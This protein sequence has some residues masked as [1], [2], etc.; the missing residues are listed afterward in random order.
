[1]RH[2]SFIFVLLLLF[3]SS[4]RHYQVKRILS[5][6]ESL[7]ETSP[8]SALMLLEA[9]DYPEDLKSPQ[10]EEYNLYLVWAKDKCEKDISSDTLVY[11][12]AVFFEKKNELRKAALA[13][14]YSGRVAFQHEELEQTYS[15]LIKAK[16]FA[17]LLKEDNLLGLISY[18][19]GYMFQREFNW[20]Q[21][22]S[23][24]DLAQRYFLKAENKRNAHNIYPVIAYLYLLEGYPKD[25]A[26][27]YYQK[28]LDYALE[29]KDSS[30]VSIIYKGMGVA[31]FENNQHDEAREYIQKAIEMDSKGQLSHGYY[32]LLS[33][34]YMKDKEY[35][36]AMYYAEKFGELVDQM[37]N[38]YYKQ[39]Y[40]TLLCEIDEHSGNYESA[41]GRYKALSVY[42]DG[43]YAENI[44]NSLADVQE[45][46]HAERIQN[47]YNRLMVHRQFLIIVIVFVLLLA[48]FIFWFFSSMVK[49]KNQ[50]LIEAEDTLEML[51]NMLLEKDNRE[52]QFKSLLI[53]KLDIAKKVAQMEIAPAK[54]HNLFLKR[55]NAVFD[56]NLQEVLDWENLYPLINDLY[57]GFIDK[58]TKLFP[59]LNEKEIQMCCLIRAGFSNNEIAFILAYTY[60][61][62]R[63]RKVDLR[64]KMGFS[65]N[66][67]FQNFFSQD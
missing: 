42:K 60:E 46:Y 45:K 36:S 34:S 62:V 39:A 25:S 54:D 15:F 33:R 57:K 23:N 66:M 12:S 19:L 24:Y 37:N 44:Q 2:I 59:L 63:V 21:A 17:L 52:N 5:Q 16:E 53:E 14:F 56:E 41:L 47:A 10:F 27:V 55:Y 9:L 8:D 31:C 4:C 48:A 26:F 13:N 7:I 65:S 49:K 40:L 64:K 35:G 51:N 28:G 67:E 58:V 6:V 3:F 1:M 50:N 18:D 20:K 32:E 11:R 29:Q 61:S 43:L 30:T 38:S 22:R